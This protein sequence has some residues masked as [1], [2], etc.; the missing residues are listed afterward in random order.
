M[1]KGILVIIAILVTSPIHAQKL[2]DL[3]KELG[4][5]LESAAQDR[6]NA[7]VEQMKEEADRP[8]REAQHTALVERFD[9]ARS[10]TWAVTTR[11]GNKYQLEALGIAGQM[12]NGMNPT[13]FLAVSANVDFSL[14]RS[15]EVS[16]TYRVTARYRD[17]ASGGESLLGQLVSTAVNNTIQARAQN[18]ADVQLFALKGKSLEK[19]DWCLA[20]RVNTVDSIRWIP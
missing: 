10:N 2:G 14:L 7:Y 16:K 12:S 13:D 3:L 5:Q 6:A 8:C 20:S 4:K 11:D 9:E 18:S 1:R 19:T 15:D 17:L